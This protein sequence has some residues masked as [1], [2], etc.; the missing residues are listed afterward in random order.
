MA[1]VKPDGVHVLVA[2][3]IIEDPVSGLTI[4][5]ERVA[6][7]TGR[8]RIYGDLPYGNREFVFDKNG[9]EAG[10]GTALTGLC[11]A[12]WLRKVP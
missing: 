10:A 1:T 4:Q 3:Q 12:S 7:G 2:E 9:T 11:R 8:M 6:D 5:F